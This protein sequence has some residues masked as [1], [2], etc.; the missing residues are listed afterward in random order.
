MI[1]TIKIRFYINKNLHRKSRG[2]KG[3][4]TGN[5]KRNIGFLL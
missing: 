3:Y 4:S 1:K 5:F 2:N